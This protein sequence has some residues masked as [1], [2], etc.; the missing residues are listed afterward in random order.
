MKHQELTSKIKVLRTGK[1]WSQEQLA[2]EAKLS[3][4]TIQRIEKGE[5][6]PR[7]DTLIKLTRVL[8]VSTDEFTV[9]EIR[10]DQSFVQLL[11]WGAL[12]FVLHPLLGVVIP[13]IMWSLKRGKIKGVDDTG[14]EVINFQMTWSLVLYLFLI[15]ATIIVDN[16]LTIPFNFNIMHSFFGFIHE[17]SLL[18]G[19]LFSYYLF[20]VIFVLL[21]VRRAQRGLKNKCVPAIIFLK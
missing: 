11:N 21:N 20:N 13:M 10:Q 19:V 3:L 5:S 14:K 1:G 18:T 9:Y 2:E 7:G 17:F 8:D 15:S 4:R 6:I 16:K 12:S